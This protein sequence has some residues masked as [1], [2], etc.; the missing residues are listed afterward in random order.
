MPDADAM[1]LRRL[2][3]GSCRKAHKPDPI[4]A[5]A[6]R[7]AP[8]L[9]LWTGDYVYPRKP[10]PNTPEA[11]VSA[12]ATGAASENE[13]LLREATAAHFGVDGVY[14]DHDYGI[15]DGGRHH[16]HREAAR[17][18]FLDAVVGAPADSLRRSRA[19]G[20]YTARTVGVPPRQVK[21]LLLDTRYGRDDHA[22]PSV[23]ASPWLPKPGLFAAMLRLLCAALGVGAS[24][25]GRVLDEEQW[26]W[27]RSELTNSTASAHLIVSS[28][29]ART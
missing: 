22:L 17:Q 26:A 20:L 24:H 2:A 11:L 29:Q 5:A 1:P 19:G 28:I 13:R 14:D 8:E 21:I 9:W 18:L 3:F 12:Y 4:L 6:A 10:Y 7:W 15:N 25:A 23:G 27:L 16:P